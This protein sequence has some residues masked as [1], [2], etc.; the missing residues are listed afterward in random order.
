MT[1]SYLRRLLALTVAWL[2]TLAAAGV[3]V[4]LASVP[5]D[6]SV[7]GDDGGVCG[8]TVA[9]GDLDSDG[10]LDFAFSEGG[11]TP[12]GRVCVLF[13]PLPLPATLDLAAVTPPLC[14]VGESGGA[15]SVGVHVRVENLDGDDHPELII[16][17]SSP[18]SGNPTGLIAVF[19]GR[20]PWPSELRLANA[21]W[22]F[23]G[24]VGDQ[25]SFAAAGDLNGDGIPDMVL[26]A[27]VADGPGAARRDAGEVYIFF[28]PIGRLS[29]GAHDPAAASAD[30]TIFGA[31][32]QDDRNLNGVSDA[33]GAR[34]PLVADLLGD[35][36]PDLIVS[37]NGGCGPSNTRCGAAVGANAGEVAVLRGRR[38]WPAAID[39]RF[40]P[41]DF[42]VY[43]PGGD[44]GLSF[45]ASGDVDGDGDLDLVAGAPRYS[46]LAPPRSFAGGLWV[47]RGRLAPGAVDLGA[48]GRADHHVLGA[49]SQGIGAGLAVADVNGDGFMD[50]VTAG[51]GSLSG[52]WSLHVLSG[53][54]GHPAFRDLAAQP[55]ELE[56]V[57]PA[58]GH[59]W[60]EPGNGQSV[61]VADIDGDGRADL[62][63]GAHTS[64]SLGALRPAGS[65]EA[66]LVLGRD[67]PAACS[68][69]ADAGS[70][71]T[72]CGAGDVALDGSATVV[73]AC[74][75]PVE[76]RWLLGTTVVRGWSPDPRHLEPVSSSGTYRLEV[77]C[78]EC[79]TP[80]L[81]VSEVEVIVQP[82]APPP[83]LG[84]TL[85]SVRLGTDVALSWAGTSAALTYR[86]YRHTDKASWPAPPHRSDL[87][88]T[89]LTL[90]DVAVPPNDPL[91]YY[92]AVGA[93][94]SGQE[95]P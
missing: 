51:R 69:T 82:N 77:R 95:G 93:S 83:D 79:P 33:L 11:Y 75:V 26:G 43:G 8:G 25:L 23:K 62:F 22:T 16:A 40:A 80:C 92:R 74:T 89:S 64:R 18:P 47:F 49:D 78:G 17:G 12:G 27:M 28:G 36:I 70:A 71:H 4:D 14:V 30:V 65:G 20:A 52:R 85:R 10:N 67:L 48:G 50:I 60:G 61:A 76:Y 86:L 54:A 66:H 2:P 21:D 68:V 72:L 19:R 87:P 84:N 90:T 3:V 53:C 5:P 35:A 31:D 37:A 56:L 63:A 45:F 9:I 81:S 29:P 42:I 32:A 44:T 6:L 34:V 58:L 91:Y 46:P 15:W 24:R 59:L 39:L 88:A 38:S 13:G 41:P 7:W 1:R 55:A 73:G 57:A 94:C